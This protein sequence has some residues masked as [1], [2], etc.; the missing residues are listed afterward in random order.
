MT[1][2]S[3]L[4][5]SSPRSI[6]P[7][8]IGSFQRLEGC[9]RFLRLRLHTANHDKNWLQ[10]QGLQKQTIPPLLSVSGAR[11]EKI[12][13]DALQIGS[14]STQQ[15]A[16]SA[17]ETASST[18]NERLLMSARALERGRSLTLSQVSL[19][20]EVGNWRLRGVLDLL[21]LTRAEN[22]ELHVL[23]ADMKASMRAKVEHRLQLAFYF[24]MIETLFR[25]AD[26]SIEKLEFGVLYR[27]S[28]EL[29]EIAP[30][31]QT[32]LQSHQ[33]AA[34]E[35]W[36][37]NDYY[38][39]LC[40]DVPT[41]LNSLDKLVF[42]SDSQART[43]A[44]KDF[45]ELAWHLSSKCDACVFSEFCLH[46]AAQSED[47][48][49]LPYLTSIEKSSLHK[50]G[51]RAIS[52]LAALKSP[53]QSAPSPGDAHGWNELETSVSHQEK[54]A[55]IAGDRQ[56][57]ARLDELIHRAHAFKR[58]PGFKSFIPSKGEGTLPFVSPEVNA[59]I[60]RIYLDGGLDYVNNRAYLLGAL[61]VAYRGG[62]EISRRSVVAMAPHAPTEA[63]IERELIQDF[64]K[65]AM[66]IAPK[67][68]HEARYVDESG[69]VRFEAP[70]HIT[71]F[72][73]RSQKIWLESLGRHIPIV[74]ASA[75]IFDFLKQLPSGDSF[76]VST[77]DSEARQ[78][79]NFPLVAPSLQAL[80]RYL[81]FDWGNFATQFRRGIF[82][83]A[84][85]VDEEWYTARSRFSSQIPLEYAYGAWNSLPEH[86][87]GND[88]FRGF[89][90][91]FVDDL[92]AF[93]ARRLDAIEHIA[94]KFKGNTKTTIRPYKLDALIDFGVKT[95]TF[96]DALQTFLQLERLAEL[97]AWKAARHA[98]P[99]RRML[100]GDSLVVRYLESDQT[101]ESRA[102]NRK[103]AEVSAAQKAFRV[104]NP[105]GRF[106]LEIATNQVV[107]DFPVRLR[108]DASGCDCCLED[109]LALSTL[110]ENDGLWLLER[111]TF[112]SR[113]PA[114]Q[115]IKFHPT[116]RQLL[117]WS[118]NATL[119]RAPYMEG[120]AAFVD[121]TPNSSRSGDGHNF[122]FAGKNCVFEDGTIY[123]LDKNANDW[124]GSA[125]F[126]KTGEIGDGEA[127][128]VHA[129]LGGS[130]TKPPSSTKAAEGQMRFLRGLQH[131]AQTNEKFELEPSKHRYIGELG[132]APLLLV[133]G[134]P[135]TGKTY[136]TAFALL[137]RLQGAMNAN[138]EWRIL[139]SAHTHSAVNVALRDV[140]DALERLRAV[141]TESPELFAEFFDA[142][143]LQIPLFRLQ[144]TS[145]NFVDEAHLTPLWCDKNE[146]A[147][148][149]SDYVKAPDALFAAPHCIAGGVPT[150]VAKVW[151]ADKNGTP[152]FNALVVDEASQ[153]NQP[154]ACLASVAN[155]LD[156][157]LIVV[158]DPRQM[159]PITKHEWETESH[160][161]FEGQPAF[162]SLYA[163]ALAKS[164]PTIK[165]EQ[166][167][168]LHARMAQFLCESIYKFDGINYHS[169]QTKTLPAPPTDN[170]FL[171]AV[172][173]SDHPIVLIEHDE[174]SS[175]LE[176][177]RENAILRPLLELLT[178][179]NHYNLDAAQGLGIVVPHRAQ[180]AL[181][182]DARWKVDTVER[183]QGDQR[184]VMAF[185]ATESDGL[186]LLQNGGFLFDPRRLCVSLSRAK[187]KLILVAA[188]SVFDIV[189]LDEETFL[190]ARLWHR[191]RDEFC[192]HPLWQ[193]E[194]EGAKVG[195]WGSGL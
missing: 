118:K 150:G 8:D 120:G 106:P 30:G 137:A 125:C 142:R 46:S 100:A 109:A 141:Q 58:T 113:L 79:K 71:F 193:G 97:G 147:K 38:F 127:N 88:L 110:R 22:G 160:R 3:P 107:Y 95:P 63:R 153:M 10:K 81:K 64:L 65:Q 27:G 176:N 149:E 157:T 117:T 25:Q 154:L 158:G 82:D 162:Q 1:P 191:L 128:F 180:R 105:K 165:F 121:V 131:L 138:R 85:T 66:Q 164:P 186:Y 21:R 83:D 51:I 13:E 41:Y 184:R 44:D 175:I 70:V 67:M 151:R 96:V 155:T 91:I 143:L 168:R 163:A 5:F 161:V 6:S 189:P 152:Y 57:G 26:V 111:E 53:R 167:Y 178:D 148:Y 49:L 59:N 54:V 93:C 115:Q 194:V 185:S 52:D 9:E 108:I 18:A 133:Q 68:A 102:Q 14:D 172:L 114:E 36:N 170:A 103:N 112:D 37:L 62:E 45:D 98:P 192:T 123:S 74:M 146:A 188:K 80:G 145:T 76:V 182:S 69:E 84:R 177:P 19:E 17:N 7:T 43:L 187:E 33:A 136:A 129:L 94:S 144:G 72:D 134:P 32:L 16:A 42:N 90:E 28:Q 156:S 60:V 15:F 50:H 86:A 92:R 2:F 169:R 116:V 130:S 39:E 181:L 31:E 23:I 61:F 190:N 99:E 75:P 73:A 195:V 174:A 166:S 124:T 55:K 104:D 183:F 171:A 12:V 29:G 179:A 87:G 40:D 48:A 173:A 122:T 140:F 4:D 126:K 47:L 20:V 135:G 78:L 56:V 24:R 101:P 119:L 89:R 34:R 139:I 77:L 132:D 11:F 159:P 35:I